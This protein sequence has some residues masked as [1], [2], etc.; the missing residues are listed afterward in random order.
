M[1][2]RGALHGA[3]RAMSRRVSRDGGQEAL[4]VMR[5]YDAVFDMPSISHVLSGGWTLRL[6][7][8]VRAAQPGAVEHR[9]HR[10]QRPV[11][12]RAPG[13]A[14]GERPGRAGVLPDE[15]AAVRLEACGAI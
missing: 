12:V 14:A 5:G 15:G 7:P 8:W 13:A 11:A 6:S 2:P 3:S 10:G 4:F 1:P 9:R